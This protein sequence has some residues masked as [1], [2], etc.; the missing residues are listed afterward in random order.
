MCGKLGGP[1]I[2][3]GKRVYSQFTALG[4]TIDLILLNSIINMFD[5]CGQPLQAVEVF[6]KFSREIKIDNITYVSAL[7]ACGNANGISKKGEEVRSIYVA[8]TI[9]NN[10]VDLF[11][12]IYRG[13]CVY[14]STCSV[15]EASC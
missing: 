11:E 2:S 4:G 9:F 5:K 13:L 1:A 6:D 15:F 12:G 8:D 10:L 7:T 14:S 3:L